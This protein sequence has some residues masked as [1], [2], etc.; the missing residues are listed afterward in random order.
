[1]PLLKK[2]NIPSIFLFLFILSFMMAFS[3]NS[4]LAQQE[5]PVQLSLFNPVQ[6]FPEE[7]A[8]KGLRLNL[9]YGKNVSVTGLD[10]GLINHT[11][12][13]GFKGL[14]YGL[15][16]I[17]DADFIGWQNNFVNVSKGEFQGFQSGLVNTTRNMSGFQ[18]GFVN[19]AD[20]ITGVQLGLVNYAGHMTRGL[21]IGIVNIIREGGKFPVFPIV[22]WAF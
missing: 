9:I 20:E 19:N 17:S 8:V 22:N 3:S 15:V 21:Q 6:L 7:T 12:S 10:I 18:Y 2:I 14:Q 13:G 11:T 4:A 1:M 5:K 16:G